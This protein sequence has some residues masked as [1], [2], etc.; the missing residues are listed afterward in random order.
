M[1]T[2]ECAQIRGRVY[3]DLNNNGMDDQ[4][5]GLAGVQVRDATETYLGYSDAVGNYRVYVDLN[6]TYTVAPT[7]PPSQWTCNTWVAGELT[8]PMSGSQTATV[9]INSVIAN[10]NDF[11]YYFVAACATIAGNVFQDQNQNGIQDN[12]E[13]GAAD[14]NVSIGNQSGGDQILT[15][16]DAQGNYM[17]MVPFGTYT[18]S[19]QPNNQTYYCNN[20]IPSI[21]TY[22]VINPT[23]TLPLTAQSPNATANN[24]GVYNSSEMDARMVN[25][26]ID[27]GTN[28][29]QAFLASMDFKITGNVTGT[30]TLRLDHDPLI[31][32]NTSGIPVTESGS[33]YAQWTFNNAI[34]NCMPLNFTLA[35]EAEAGY[36]LNWSAAITCTSPEV[37][38]NNN[39]MNRTRT[40]QT[41]P[42][43]TQEESFLPNSMVVLHTGDQQTGVIT[44]D[45]STFSYLI[46]FQNVTADT[47]H[48]VRI[49]N[50][51]SPHLDITS[52]SGPFSLNPFKMYVPDAE[53]IIFEFDNIVL[54]DSGS[55]FID[56]YGFVQYNIR[57]KPNLPD[58]TIIE[59][60]A[61]VSFNREETIPTN[62]VSNQIALPVLTDETTATSQFLRAFPNPTNGNFNVV[63]NSSINVAY[64]LLLHDAMGRVVQRQSFNH[65]DKS[66]LTIATRLSEG[67]YLLTVQDNAGQRPM[68]YQKLLIIE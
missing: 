3:N 33:D 56:S 9:D 65:K 57:M 46:N 51:I 48:L 21:Q 64:T 61:T 45:D 47:A 17:V 30:C 60:K 53:T 37:C 25:L 7:A 59:N 26:W 27:N 49:I 6:N 44:H 12:G 20:Q 31:T 5:P 29:G 40:V 10:G 13:L 58:G 54:P 14:R 4:E 67:A 23:Y 28:A 2:A 41:G 52:L 8:E 63:F 62:V 16:T 42:M 15:Q 55:S 38:T 18:V 11:G 68:G 32:L 43:K 34:S 24:F 22:P 35:P 50:T 66:E 1:L 19:L 36:V 39:T